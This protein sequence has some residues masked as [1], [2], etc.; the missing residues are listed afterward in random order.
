MDQDKV[1]YIDI[2]KETKLKKLNE[3]AERII[4]NILCRL[5][6]EQE[7]SYGHSGNVA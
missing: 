2:S 5:Y 6:M 3:E 1:I 7:E 4:C